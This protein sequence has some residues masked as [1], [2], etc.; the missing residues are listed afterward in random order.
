VCNPAASQPAARHQPVTPPRLEPQAHAAAPPTMQRRVLPPPPSLLLLLLGVP[1]HPSSALL[2][3]SAAVRQQLQHPH[4]HHQHI[5]AAAPAAAAPA[6]C[7]AYD[8]ELVKPAF[9][10]LVLPVSGGGG[11][12][13]VLGGNFYG[14]GGHISTLDICLLQ[15]PRAVGGVGWNWSRGFTSPHCSDPE[16]CKGP[17]CFADFA[18]VSLGLGVS[19]F[20][21]FAERDGTAAA[22]AAMGGPGHDGTV[23]PANLDALDHLIVSQNVSWAWRDAAPGVGP[24]QTGVSRAFPSW[25]RSILTE[26][27]LCRTCSCQE[28]WRMEMARQ[29]SRRARLIYD[30]FLTT[31]RPNGTNIAHTITD[32]ITIALAVSRPFPSWNRSIL[33]EIYLCHACSCREILRT[34]TAWQANPEFPGSQVMYGCG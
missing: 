23:L 32:E 28:I 27:S 20:A 16:V 9:P 26:I 6:T 29:G 13:A 2:A 31:A 33:T 15:D 5:V 22:A 10:R 1:L 25:K 17:T 3:K 18:F 21:S 12:T 4:P 7:V 19:P 14:A 8:N 30:F 34:E 11:M 24:P